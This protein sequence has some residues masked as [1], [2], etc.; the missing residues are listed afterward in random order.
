[1]KFL[2]DECLSPKLVNLAA[3]R[4][5][6]ESTHIA[7]R[8]LAGKKDWE[9]KPIILDGDWSFVTRNSV[10]F[11]GPFS[12]PGSRGVY[13]DV[14]IHAGLICLNGPDGMK[15]DVQLELFGQALEEL[16]IDG[17]LIN[18]VLEI[19]LEENQ[20]LHILRYSLPAPI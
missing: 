14:A 1:V 11:R 16:A 5:Y 7:W 2:V 17:D 8:K 20:E 6:G 19:T 9:L 3:E 13:V 10:D 18:Q 15:V 12:K 4:G